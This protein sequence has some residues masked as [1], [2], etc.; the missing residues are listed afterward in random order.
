MMMSNIFNGAPTISRGSKR[1]VNIKGRRES[2]INT[3][4]RESQSL[5]KKTIVPKNIKVKTQNSP[6]AALYLHK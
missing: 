5:G 1:Q 3:K 4:K 2:S 6:L